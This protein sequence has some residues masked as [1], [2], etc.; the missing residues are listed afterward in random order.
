M[1]AIFGNRILP[2]SVLFC[3]LLFFSCSSK[4]DV[5][6]TIENNEEQTELLSQEEVVT[7]GSFEA[8]QDSLRDLLLSLKPSKSLKSSLLQELYIR[9]LVSQEENKIS[10]ILPFNLHGLDC[11]APDCYS[12]NITFEIPATRPIEFPDEVNFKLHEQGCVEQ[13]SMVN[14]QFSLDEKSNEFVNYYS[15]ELKSNLVID[16]DGG[17]Y[18]FPHSKISS[19]KMET[20]KNMLKNKKFDNDEI[21]PYRSTVMTTN[22]YE[23]FFKN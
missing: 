4:E 19:V 8:T 13:E 12:T 3:S 7:S 20:I 5:A 17:L 23:H 6:E 9:G 10:F 15:S 16:N 2:T 21:V 1:K 14:S 11:G 22:E 18:Y